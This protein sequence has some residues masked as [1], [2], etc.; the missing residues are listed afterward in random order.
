MVNLLHLAEGVCRIKPQ[1]GE[2]FI[3]C[4]RTIFLLTALSEMPSISLNAEDEI[5][6]NSVSINI[7]C[8]TALFPT[9]SGAGD[10]SHDCT[11]QKMIQTRTDEIEHSGSVNSCR[12]LRGLDT[13]A[14]SIL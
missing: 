11:C 10:R 9:D 1:S 12:P 2:M 5:E 14:I 3:D 8:L 13:F 4:E 6:G 7:S